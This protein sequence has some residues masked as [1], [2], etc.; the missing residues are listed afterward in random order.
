MDDKEAIERVSTAARRSAQFQMRVQYTEENPQD[1]P[2]PDRMVGA[3]GRN[4]EDPTV[5]IDY[6]Q[7]NISGLIGVWYLTEE[8]DVPVAEPIT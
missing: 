3:W 1:F 8:G 4:L 2:R 7:H 6:V 5:R